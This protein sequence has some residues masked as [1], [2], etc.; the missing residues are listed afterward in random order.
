MG[1]TNPIGEGDVPGSIRCARVV[2]RAGIDRQRPGFEPAPRPPVTSSADQPFV[3]EV[4]HQ[5]RW[6]DRVGGLTRGR[7]YDPGEVPIE[8]ITPLFYY[9]LPGRILAQLTGCL[10]CR[11]PI[12]QQKSPIGCLST[13]TGPLQ[14]ACVE[15]AVTASSDDDDV[16]ER[17]PTGCVVHRRQPELLL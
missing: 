12:Y 16:A 5:G 14:L 6:N 2:R 8:K 1:W 11:V 15:G 7:R 17:Y 3:H 9:Y 4:W 13:F 10:A